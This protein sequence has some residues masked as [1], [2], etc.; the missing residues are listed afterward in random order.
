MDRLLKELHWL[1]SGSN[2]GLAENLLRQ[3]DSSGN[4]ST[5]QR[6]VGSAFELFGRP[7]LP[8]GPSSPT[9]PVQQSELM[10]KALTAALSGERKGLPQWTGGVEH[11][12]GSLRIGSWTITFPRADG[13]ASCCNH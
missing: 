11:G 2:A 13:E 12:F 9:S 6:P 8:Q 3:L 7:I 1:G 4:P 10:L 5:Q